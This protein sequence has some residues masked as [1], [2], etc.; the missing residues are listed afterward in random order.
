MKEIELIV[1]E[2]EE[3]A[4]AGG[5]T[6]IKRIE[7]KD[8]IVAQWVRNKCMF[9]C[10]LYG[11]RFTC[12]PY[13]ST[14]EETAAILSGYQDALLVQFSDLLREKQKVEPGRSMVH[15]VMYGMEK[16]AFL[17]GYEKAFA[18]KA[19]PCVMCVEC[20]AEKLESPGPFYKKLC[21]LAKEARPSLEAVGV[22]VYGT[23]RR[24]GFE[25]HVLRERTEKFKCFGLLLLS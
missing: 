1:K 17:S 25:I 19:G 3:I 7:P 9:G 21:K 20:P 8:V 22:D 5:A 10:P 23:A 2:L 16:T 24:A 14:P 12:P 11:K 4:L 18:Y 6:A 15:K 13:C